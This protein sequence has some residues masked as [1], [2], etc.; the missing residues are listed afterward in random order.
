LPLFKTGQN[1]RVK[2]AQLQSKIS[3]SNLQQTQMQLTSAYTQAIQQFNKQ[4][5]AVNYYTT[6]GL[7]LANSLRNTASRSYQAGDIGYVEYLQNTR[8]A[9][10]IQVAALSALRDFN[11]SIIELNFLFNK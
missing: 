2:A 8:R 1:T 10:E 9:F 7:Q 4:Q 11:Q 6:E 3:E 5:L